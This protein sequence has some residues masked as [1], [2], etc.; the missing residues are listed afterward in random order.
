MLLLAFFLCLTAVVLYYVIVRRYPAGP[1]PWPLVGNL[2]HFDVSRI[3]WLTVEWKQNFGPIYTIWI[4]YPVV[5]FAGPEVRS[6]FAKSLLEEI[7]E[8]FVKNG[9]AFAGR[10]STFA[11]ELTSF[12]QHGLVFNDNNFYKEQRRFALRALRDLGVGREEMEV[13]RHVHS[14]QRLLTHLARRT[15]ENLR[16]TGGQPVTLQPFIVV[17]RFQ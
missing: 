16:E 4:P 3:E 1:F 2:L 11:M 9:E 5:I 6:I 8:H 7:K 13:R 14:W 12:G 17:R 10:P 15:T